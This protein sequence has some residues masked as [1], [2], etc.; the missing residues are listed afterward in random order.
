MGGSEQVL[1]EVTGYELMPR[2]ADVFEL[3]NKNGPESI[4]EIQF[5]D[6]NEGLHSSFFYTFL[7]QR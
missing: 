5:K 3:A 1:K 2:Y 4:F 7:V 6:G